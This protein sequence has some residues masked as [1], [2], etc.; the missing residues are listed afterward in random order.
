MIFYRIKPYGLGWSLEMRNFGE[1]TW[2]QIQ[3][4]DNYA[5]ALKDKARYENK[6]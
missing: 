4:Y 6:Y 2:H 5:A 1:E 3:L